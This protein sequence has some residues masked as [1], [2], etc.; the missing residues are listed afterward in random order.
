MHSVWPPQRFR[1]LN[2]VVRYTIKELLDIISQHTP[3]KRVDEATLD[4]G[5][6]EAVPDISRVMMSNIADQGT[7]KGAKGSKK[8]RKRRPWWVVVAVGYN[9]D[10]DNNEKVDD[11]NKEYVVAIECYVKRHA[12]LL[13]DHFRRLLEV[14]YPNHVYSVN[15]KIKKCNMMKNFI[16]S[17]ALTKGK[18]PEGDPGGKGM[19]PFPT[20]EAVMAIYDR[21]PLG[22]PRF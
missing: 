8:R 17:G 1:A 18:E 14:A 5:D 2:D 10:D 19:T 6:W 15:H 9:D 20:E 11:S 7:K 22:T 3:S 4:P 21:C 16:T 13:I 12:W